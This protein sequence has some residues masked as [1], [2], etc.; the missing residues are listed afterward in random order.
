MV[1]ILMLAAVHQGAMIADQ[2]VIAETESVEAMKQHPRANLT[3]VLLA[4]AEMARAIQMRILRGVQATVVEEL[5]LKII[6]MEYAAMESLQLRVQEIVVEQRLAGAEMAH[7]I[8][9]RIPHGVQK[10]A[11]RSWAQLQKNQQL[12]HIIH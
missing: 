3:A 8:Q 2:A 10:I 4:G 12:T 5:V 6:V 7:A 1:V 9:M 11:A